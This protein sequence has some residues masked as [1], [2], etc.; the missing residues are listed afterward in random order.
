MEWNT[1]SFLYEFHFGT[2]YN[3][4]IIFLMHK[5]GIIIENK[6]IYMTRARENIFFKSQNM[7]FI[8]LK[9]YCKYIHR[10]G[11]ISIFHNPK[12]FFD[13]LMW[14]LCTVR[15]REIALLG[16]CGHLIWNYF[17]T[18][19]WKNIQYYDEGGVKPTT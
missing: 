5:N 11:F 18:F 9:K 12:R 4:D 2:W 14:C 16:E 13:S 19:S 10:V 17:I 3:N 7:Y 6:Y 8:F 1:F 15:P